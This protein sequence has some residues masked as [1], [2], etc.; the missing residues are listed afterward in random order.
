MRDDAVEPLL[1]HRKRTRPLLNVSEGC[2][3]VVWYRRW[4]NGIH[5][6]FDEFPNTGRSL[7]TH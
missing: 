4:D 5:Q 2:F 3:H 1:N 7:Q 6:G